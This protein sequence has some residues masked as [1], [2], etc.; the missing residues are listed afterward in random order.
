MGRTSGI[1]VYLDT[2]GSYIEAVECWV[3]K[4]ETAK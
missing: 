4:A 3:S 2:Y 1:D